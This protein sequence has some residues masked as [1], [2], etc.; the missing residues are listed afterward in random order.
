MQ[1]HQ[2]CQ[3]LHKNISMIIYF[4][5]LDNPFSQRQILGK[6]N[7]I[8]KIL[9]YNSPSQTYAFLPPLYNAAL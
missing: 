5:V 8:I 1:T 4:P 7:F 2:Y 3:M 6:S 9:R